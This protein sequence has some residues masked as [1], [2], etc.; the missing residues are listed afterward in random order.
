MLLEKV[1]TDTYFREYAKNPKSEEARIKA[2]TLAWSLTYFLA[3][4][5]L[6]GLRR[7]HAELRKLPRDLEFDS[8]TLLLAF[9]RAFDCVDASSPNTVDRV[10]LSKLADQW[11]DVMMLEK[12]ED[13][14]LLAE[15]VK[16]QTELRSQGPKPAEGGK[17]GAPK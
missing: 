14:S 4:N 6:D 10:K 7:Y 8:Q 9:A 3:K 5:K 13:E 11:H 12:S 16:A 17:P 1:V 2:H 15:A